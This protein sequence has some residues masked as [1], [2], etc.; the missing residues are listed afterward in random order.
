M[1]PHRL[2]NFL[3]PQVKPVKIPDCNGRAAGIS[4]MR[5]PILDGI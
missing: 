5:R 3:V 4:E 1:F 2:Q